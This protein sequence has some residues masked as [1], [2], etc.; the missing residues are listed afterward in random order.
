M[1]ARESSSLD[2][3][4]RIAQIENG[5][6]TNVIEADSVWSSNAS[7]SYMESDT[8]GIGWLLVDG[9]LQPAPIDYVSLARQHVAQFFPPDLLIQ[10]MFWY[11]AIPHDATPKLSS[12]VAWTVGVT[13]AASQGSSNF[14]QPPVTFAEVMAE[15]IPLLS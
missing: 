4:M 8:A 12:L 10:C 9:E 2:T 13:V 6:V 5:K 15:C 1:E 3:N 11:G 14:Q 7:I